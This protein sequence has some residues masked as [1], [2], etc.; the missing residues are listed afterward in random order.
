MTQDGGIEGMGASHAHVTSTLPK[1]GSASLAN[2]AGGTSM[3]V[4]WHPTPVI[5]ARPWSASAKD[6]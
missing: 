2:V 1:S 6:R 3:E 5:W 4:G